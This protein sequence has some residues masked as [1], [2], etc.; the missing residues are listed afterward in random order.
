MDERYR[1][2]FNDALM[3]IRC[4]NDLDNWDKALERFDFKTMEL[5]SPIKENLIEIRKIWE[6]LTC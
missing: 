2:G 4:V 1:D 5:S 6:I 3:F